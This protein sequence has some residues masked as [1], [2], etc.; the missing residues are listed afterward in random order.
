MIIGFCFRDISVEHD[1]YYEKDE[2]ASTL[3]HSLGNKSIIFKWFFLGPNQ[4]EG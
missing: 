3:D 4:T 1:N 2:L